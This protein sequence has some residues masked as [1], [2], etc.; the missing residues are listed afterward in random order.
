MKLIDALAVV[1]DLADQNVLEINMCD[2]KEMLQERREQV[3]AVKIAKKLLATL[4]TLL[5]L[6]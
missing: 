3:A 5:R 4:K 6:A 1:I 2:D